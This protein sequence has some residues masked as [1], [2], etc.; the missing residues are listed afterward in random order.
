MTFVSYEFIG[1]TFLVMALYFIFPLKIR[2][3]VLLAA[4]LFFYWT[5]GWQKMIF[6]GAAAVITYVCGLLIGRF[7]SESEAG[8]KARLKAQTQPEIQ[9]VD[10]SEANTSSGKMSGAKTAG[11]KT[12]Q[13]DQTQGQD[14]ERRRAAAL[15]VLLIG[16]VLLLGMLAYV[17]AAGQLMRALGDIL[18]G[19]GITFSVIIP[20]GIS[21][22]TFAAI[23]YLAD[24]YWKTD[25]AEKNPLKLILYLCYFPQILQGP[26]PKHKNLS[27][28]L[29]EGHR[30]DYNRVCFGLQRAV[31]GFFQKLV[32]ADR[33]AIM[34]SQVFDHYTDYSG[35]IFVFAL[36]GA[37]FQLYADFSGCM[38]IALGVSEVFGITLE[39]NFKRPFYAKSAAEFWRRWHI[40]LGAWFKDYV[41]MPLS[42]APWL[43]SLGKGVKKLFGRKVARNVMTTIP[44][45]VVWILTGLW[46][47]TGWDYV[48]WGL[49]WG[50]IIILSTWLDPVYKKLN[51]RFGLRDDLGWWRVTRQVRTFLIYMV[52]RLL[53]IPGNLATSRWIARKI[54]TWNP[55]VL[56]DGTFFRLGWD[57]KDAWAGIIALLILWRVSYLKE[58]GVHIR[59]AIAKWPLPIRWAFYYGAIFAVLIFGIYGTGVSA[60]SFVYMNY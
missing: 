23:G 25:T 2:Y 30:F 9:A 12:G 7:R 55:W 13:P 53:T 43:I 19:Q 26:I 22:Y 15:A 42:T 54:F 24:V 27:P 49:Y 51:K 44:L 18:S 6:L 20:L 33:L 17:K 21:Y 5:A 10:L 28:Q 36:V 52:G 58:K 3:F 4:S 32:I 34:T 47:G 37:V 39:E 8:T 1:F 60:A 14:P 41:Y 45:L 38:D 31:W 57:Y 48:V 59:E 35:L 56:F 40:T 50:G 16:V 29:C 11:A 46:H